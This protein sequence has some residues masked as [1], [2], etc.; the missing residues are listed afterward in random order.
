MTIFD[1]EDEY[2]EKIDTTQV[3]CTEQAL[4]DKYILPNDKVLELG[5]RYGSVSCV[6]NSKLNN[7]KNLVVVEPD[8]RVWDSLERNKIVNGCEFNI[9]KG[10][11]SDKKLGL[12]NLNDYS[13]YG[14]T[15][16]EN[17][18]SDIPI[19][20]LQDIKESYNLD[21]NVIVADCEGCLK[22]FLSENPS[23]LDNLRLFIFESDYP[24]VCNYNEINEILLSKNFVN[25]L[26]GHQ[27]V[28]IKNI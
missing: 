10:F 12:Y 22:F 28:W 13:G 17:E 14:T 9:V 3:E 26:Q 2:G 5:G 1:I 27:N 20:S 24:D 16:I 25:H 4:V 7:P 18:L 11:I 23:I 8:S 15:S 6:I 21:F 19:Y